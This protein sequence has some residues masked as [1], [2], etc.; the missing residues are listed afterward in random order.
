MAFSSSTGGVHNVCKYLCRLCG[1]YVPIGD[2]VELS[3]YMNDVNRASTILECLRHVEDENHVRLYLNLLP[4]LSDEVLRSYARFCSPCVTRAEQ[5]FLSSGY[6]AASP[7]WSSDDNKGFSISV[8]RGPDYGDDVRDNV[9]SHLSQSSSS[10]L[11]MSSDDKK[12]Y[13]EGDSFIMEVEN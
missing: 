8:T 6:G 13:D 2:I 4:P 12:G 9:S 1:K 11:A 7:Q 10:D 3:G 5:Y